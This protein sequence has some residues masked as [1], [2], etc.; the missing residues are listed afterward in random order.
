MADT[1]MPEGF[2]ARH[3]G[4]DA[5][6]IA[7]MLEALGVGSL[8][9]LI[10]RAVPDTIPDHSRPDLPAPLREAEALIWLRGLADGNQVL[11]SLIGQAYSDTFTPPVI[12]RNVL[13]NPAWY[14]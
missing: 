7:T 4:P 12:Q 5:A 3:I 14:T 6:E 8:E 1:G 10:D 2:A 11:T 13:E 9:E